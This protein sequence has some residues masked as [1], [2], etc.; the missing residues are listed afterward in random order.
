MLTLL[1][2][3]TGG[4]RKDEHRT[5]LLLQAEDHPTGQLLDVWCKS[6]SFWFK[7]LAQNKWA[8]KKPQIR[9]SRHRSDCSSASTAAMFSCDR[10]RSSELLIWH[11]IKGKKLK[12][13]LHPTMVPAHPFSPLS[14]AGRH[15]FACWPSNHVTIS[16]HPHLFYFSLT[17]RLNFKITSLQFLC[18]SQVHITL[19]HSVTFGFM[20]H[21]VV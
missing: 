9:K 14:P 4:W 3:V 1:C 21:S 19:K 10:L 18:F 2:L 6:K 17:L 7:L 8:D 15:I 13:I 5:I 16:V 12:S 11:K 20:L